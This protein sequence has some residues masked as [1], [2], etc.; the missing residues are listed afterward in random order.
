MKKLGIIIA[1]ALI[2]TIGGAYATW[3]YTTG[4]SQID[5]VTTTKGITLVA[6]AEQTANGGTIT[7]TQSDDFAITVDDD[8]S[9]NATLTITGSITISY[10]GGTSS[11][12]E[13]VNGLIL[14]VS[15]EDDCT[16]YNSKDV[17]KY[18]TITSSGEVGNGTPFATWTLSAEELAT[19]IQLNGTI[20]A[21]TVGDYDALSTAI[22]TGTIT[23]TV[24]A[25]SSD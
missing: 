21:P 12:G 2:V 13:T 22:S 9:H 25:G 3:N 15:A 20:S 4:A 23:L 16:Q 14:Q 1:L 19:L 17:F 18:T 11:T 8:G 5:A 24:S 10:S 7:V 6:K